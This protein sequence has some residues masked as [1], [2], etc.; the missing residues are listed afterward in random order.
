VRARGK[1]EAIV[2]EVEDDMESLFLAHTNAFN[3]WINC[4]SMIDIKDPCR[5]F[6]W[7]NNQECPIMATLDRILASV[8]WDAK[9]LLVKV[10]ILHKGVNGYNPLV[11]KFGE[12]LQIK[13]PIFKSEKCWLEVEGLSE[14][15]KKIWDTG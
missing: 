11:I 9:H 4:W 10:T 13:D 12:K 1:S 7:S 2:K 14:L 6:T 8:D 15:V 3:D 5:S